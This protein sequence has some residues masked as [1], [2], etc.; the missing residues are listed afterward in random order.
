MSVKI[1]NFLWD[2]K[3]FYKRNIKRIYLDL[4]ANY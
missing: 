3:M 2:L 1:Y 4:G